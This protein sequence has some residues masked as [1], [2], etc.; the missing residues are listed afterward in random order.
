M[1]LSKSISISVLLFLAPMQPFAGDDSAVP[2]DYDPSYV[3]TKNTDGSNN[4]D[5][6]FPFNVLRKVDMR[7]LSVHSCRDIPLETKK[8]VPAICYEKP[9][10]G[11]I[12]RKISRED[13]KYCRYIQ[14]TQNF[15]GI[16]CKFPM[17][18]LQEIL[19][20]LNKHFDTM[21]DTAVQLS[22]L[23]EQ[24]IKN[25]YDEYC[26]ITTE[27]SVNKLVKI[28]EDNKV[29]HVLS[30][31]HGG[32]D[33]KSTK[34][35]QKKSSSVFESVMFSNDEIEKILKVLDTLHYTSLRL[36][37]HDPSAGVHTMSFHLNSIIY[38]SQDRWAIWINGKQIDQEKAGIPGITVEVTQEKVMISWS[39]S[40]LDVVCPSW[41]SQVLKLDDNTYKSKSYDVKIIGNELS[42]VKKI[43]FT[44][45]PNQT[46]IPHNLAIVEG[47][48]S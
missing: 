4:Q 25:T 20:V 42:N 46:F 1:T 2:F 10:F 41:R 23:D 44:L 37:G 26:R 32:T 8:C 16:D 18:S 24:L 40:N 5:V 45:K 35:V 39:I 30:E 21:Y 9:V 11:L 7:Y 31:M 33:P 34:K 3:I 27:P 43:E 14:R 29:K 36:R 12:Y 48:V 15:G 19:S 6:E 22:E 17:D 28:G 13:D 38:Q 47:K